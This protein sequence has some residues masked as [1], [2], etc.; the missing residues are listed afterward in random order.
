M[1]YFIG[2]PYETLTFHV[3]LLTNQITPNHVFEFGIR[4]HCCENRNPDFEHLAAT[5]SPYENYPV[6]RIARKF[7]R[8]FNLAA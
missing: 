7:G 2:V 8:I 3:I 6:Y 4:Y 1:G 5:I